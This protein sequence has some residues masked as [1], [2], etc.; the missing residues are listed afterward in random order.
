VDL[1][2]ICW[3]CSYPLSCT[4]TLWKKFDPDTDSLAWWK[5][6]S[7]KYSTLSVLARRYLAVPATSVPSERIF[8]AAGLIVTKLRHCLASIKLF[9][10]TKTLYHNDRITFM[11]VTWHNLV[12]KYNCTHK[13]NGSHDMKQADSSI[14]IVRNVCVL[15]SASMIVYVFVTRSWSAIIG[16]KQPK[17]NKSPQQCRGR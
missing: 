17:V 12:C 6:N 8:S 10:L 11:N 3:T 4:L 14:T 1:L 16:T 9:S 2:D 7:D 5:D 15:T 13:K